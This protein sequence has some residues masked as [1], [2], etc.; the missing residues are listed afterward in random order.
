MKNLIACC[1][2]L[3]VSVSVHAEIADQVVLVR[4]EFPDSVTENYERIANWLENSGS[5]SLA[6]RFRG[7]ARGGFG[8]GSVIRTPAGRVLVLTNYHVVAQSS[9]VTLEFAGRS[10]SGAAF[11]NCRVIAADIERDLALIEVPSQA[12]RLAQPL[13]FNEALQQDG[14]EVWSAG[15]PELV[16]SPS[17]QLATGTVTNQE[18]VVAELRVPELDYVIQHSAPIGPG[19]SGGPLL[20]RIDA[21]TYEIVGVNTWRFGGR[22]NTYF[23][24]PAYAAVAFIAEYGDV[25]A[26]PDTSELEAR[27]RD[28]SQ[29]FM[30]EF[31]QRGTLDLRRMKNLISDELVSRIGWNSY[32]DYRKNLEPDERDQLDADF[33]SRDSYD[34]MKEA[35]AA[36]IGDL[37]GEAGGAMVRVRTPIDP[38]RAEVEYRLGENEEVISWKWELNRWVISGISLLD[39]E[40]QDDAEDEERSG[41]FDRDLS[42]S[43]ATIRVIGGL[44]N[45]SATEPATAIDPKLGFGVGVTIESFR[46]AFFGLSSGIEYYENSFNTSLGTSSETIRVQNLLVPISLRLQAPLRISGGSVTLIP[47]FAAGVSFGVDIGA[48]SAFSRTAA[49]PIQFQT[50]LSG[51]FEM[52]TEKLRD[53]VIW[54]LEVSYIPRTGAYA[55]PRLPPLLRPNTLTVSYLRVSATVRFPF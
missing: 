20:N 17:W 21:D 7:Y 22:D 38:E 23:S 26:I 3:I 19:S 5:A 40:A 51:G 14:T 49:N 27:L 8:S 36:R 28:A 48:L 18:A 41:L 2:A 50:P 34:A 30:D 12:E 35:V 15:Y 9:T 47:W 44:P 6:E 24:I 25:D 42:L 37:V 39:A 4:T 32:L 13:A 1:A 11:A 33:V 16:S 55:G 54:G 46:N 10:G 29:R 31:V 45:I 53:S 43:S 52:T